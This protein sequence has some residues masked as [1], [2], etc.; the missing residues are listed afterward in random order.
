MK[1]T[2]GKTAPSRTARRWSPIPDRIG[3]KY[4]RSDSEFGGVAPALSVRSAA[5][6]ESS[7]DPTAGVD[8]ALAP[9]QAEKA[10]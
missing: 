8:Q 7:S 5:A 9:R 2:R 10:E 3:I 6:L 1:I 4:S